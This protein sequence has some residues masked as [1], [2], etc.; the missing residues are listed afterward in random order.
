MQ[1][2]VTTPEHG[3]CSTIFGLCFIAV[4]YALPI[5]YAKVRHKWEPLSCKFNWHLSSHLQH[6][7]ILQTR[8]LRWCGRANVY[9]G[10]YIS[11]T[12]FCINKSLNALDHK[13]Q[14]LSYRKR[15]CL[16]SQ[17]TSNLKFHCIGFH[18]KVQIK[19]CTITRYVHIHNAHMQ[20]QPPMDWDVT[21]REWEQL[22]N[23][24]SKSKVMSHSAVTRPVRAFCAIG[25]MPLRVWISSEMLS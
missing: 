24:R 25:L 18:W 20:M 21:I 10:H 14:T 7:Q 23:L 8:G 11:A 22:I 6:K 3:E 19:I 5:S 13:E 1:G 12:Y 9:K 16:M 4:G 2:D 15:G 17:F